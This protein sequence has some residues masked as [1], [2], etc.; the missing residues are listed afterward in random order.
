MDGK[1][2]LTRLARGD[3]NWLRPDFDSVDFV[4]DV[5]VGATALLGLGWDHV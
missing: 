3:T 2:S 5:G 1:I 4:Y